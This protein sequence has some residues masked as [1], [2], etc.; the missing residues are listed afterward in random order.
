MVL[1]E[2]LVFLLQKLFSPSPTPV[3][4]SVIEAMEREKPIT[5]NKQLF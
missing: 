4:F 3:Y 2:Q 5:K 1:E